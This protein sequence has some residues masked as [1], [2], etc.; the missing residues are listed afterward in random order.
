MNRT[1]EKRPVILVTSFGTSY[2]SSRSITI[3]AIE[4]TIAESFPGYEVRR[5]FTSNNIRRILR[6]RDGIEIDGVPQAL[7]KLAEEG[8]KDVMIM[9]THMLEGDEYDN[10]IVKAAEAY[11]DRFDS[12]KVGHALLTN[13]E[14]YN[15]L[16][17][18]LRQSAEARDAAKTALVFMGH[19]TEHRANEGYAKLQRMIEARGI[20]NMFIGTVEATPTVEDIVQMV[21]KSGA[22]EVILSPLMIVAGDHATNDMAGD[23]P[24]SWKSIFES[25]G[26][27]ARCRITGLGSV[28][29]IQKMIAAHCK[30]LIQ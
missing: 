15:M 19:G 13:D 10:K 14:D 4:S 1:A 24:D 5:A 16:I 22:E 18:I 11:K 12:L 26:F 30:E 7:E 23:D 17:D 25:A 2:S 21:K 3:G 27:T 8:V 28:Y 29:G 20:R 6:E 9:P